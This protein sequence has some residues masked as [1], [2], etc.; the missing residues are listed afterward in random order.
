MLTTVSD[1]QTEFLVRN[2][3][4]T[5]DTFITDATLNNWL[6]DAHAWGVNYKK[7]PWTEG[8]VS[9]TFASFVADPEFGYLAGPYPEGWKS[10]AI[11]LLTVGGKMTTK[12]NF[13]KFQRFLEDNAQSNKRMWTDFGRIIYINPG[14]DLS[15]TVTA[16]GQ[17]TP[18]LDPTDK[19][20]I[21]AFSYNDELGNDALVEKMTSYLKAR[22]HL[23]DEVELQDKRAAQ[24]LEDLLAKITDE[25]YGYNATDDEG[26]WKRMDVIGGALRDDLF[27]RDQFY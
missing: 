27:K 22:E 20:A 9:T 1:I 25:Q 16:W 19:T 24:K 12:H 4:T 21:T 6:R 10:D 15:G 11:R 18:L 17:Y 3:R 14:I 2:N 5:T 26:M 7:W 23:P 8:R 13:Y